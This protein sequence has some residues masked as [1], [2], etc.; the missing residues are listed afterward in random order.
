MSNKLQK[1]HNENNISGMQSRSWHILVGA[2]AA[3]TVCSEPEPEP[4]KRG[5]S[6]SEKDTIMEK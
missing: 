3:K 1:N 2:G 4:K 5:G 6:G